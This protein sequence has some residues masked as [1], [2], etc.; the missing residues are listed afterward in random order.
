MYVRSD[1]AWLQRFKQCWAHV[2]N[3]SS[4]LQPPR[5]PR[6]PKTARGGTVMVQLV[7]TTAARMCRS[8]SNLETRNQKQVMAHHLQAHMMANLLALCS[9]AGGKFNFSHNPRTPGRELCHHLISD[10]VDSTPPY[11]CMI[12][13]GDQGGSCKPCHATGYYSSGVLDCESC[14]LPHCKVAS[15]QAVARPTSCLASCL[16][17][18]SRCQYP[19]C[20][21][22]QVSFYLSNA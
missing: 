4:L 22:Q 21:F 19:L 17:G 13:H 20:W 6:W 7:C 10:L 1:I 12:G 14:N 3:V 11:S 2:G 9:D 18:A 15:S 8:S 5:Q 16:A